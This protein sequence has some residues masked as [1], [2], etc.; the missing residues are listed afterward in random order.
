MLVQCWHQE[1]QHEGSSVCECWCVT[2]YVIVKVTPERDGCL[3]KHQACR[4][5]TTQVQVPQ[6]LPSI[7]D[8]MMSR[9]SAAMGALLLLLLFSTSTAARQLR[10]GGLNVQAPGVSVTGGNGEPLVVTWPGGGTVVGKTECNSTGVL[11]APGPPYHTTARHE[12][13][14]SPHTLAMWHSL[15]V[16]GETNNHSTHAAA[17][18][19]QL[20]IAGCA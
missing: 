14:T 7:K 16:I 8:A 1:L 20:R 10:E 12:Q 6:S 4:T 5:P 13:T 19:L 3:T 11:V 15:T 2:V 9:M 18:G 17:P